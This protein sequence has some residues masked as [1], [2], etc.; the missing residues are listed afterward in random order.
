MSVLAQWAGLL[1]GAF[2][3]FCAAALIEGA[4]A[5]PA[6]GV[7]ILPTLAL[8]AS[9]AALRAVLLF[10]ASRASFRASTGVKKLL[11]QRLYDKLLAL[12]G[13]GVTGAEAVQVA[14]EGI[15]QI[16]NYFGRYLPQLFY[17]VLAPLTLFCLLAPVSLSSAAILLACAPLIPLLIAL[18]NAMARRMMRKQLSSYTSLGEFF[19]ESL[20]GMTTLKIY[21]ADGA[22]HAEMNGLAESFRRSTM[23]VLRMQLNSIIFMD[24]IA[25]GGAAL[26]VILAVRGF[27][28]GGIGMAGAVSITLLAAEFFIPLR[29]LGSYFHV[30]MNG[31]AACER[32]FQILDAPE[33]ADG[34]ESLPDGG[35]TLE[36]DGL[37]FSY[38]QGREA[39]SGLS[40]SAPAAGLTGVAGPSGCGKS[41]VA[42]LVA[43]RL[44]GREYRG[45]A[46]VGGVELRDIRLSE[47]RRRVCLVTHEDY[48]FAGTVADNLLMAKP[49]ATPQE[50]EGALRTAGLYGFFAGAGGLG[51]AVAE[52]GAN[53]SGG[54]RQ[55]LSIA[56]AALR[57]CGLY[58]FD[59]ATSSIDPESEEGILSAAAEISKSASVLMISHRLASLARADAIYAM[60]GG[61][62]A[63]RGSHSEL[64]AAGGVYGRLLREQAELESF[65]GAEA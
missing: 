3:I 46:K 44:P 25:Y 28:A 11:R 64:A 1:C 56:R 19:L 5:P 47:L 33:P 13:G 20:R 8:C 14:V 55:R 62:A 10:L 31:V 65:R 51:A 41:T 59:E 50:L 48:I 15:D 39:L 17:S 54:Q 38:G 18:I 45:S 26:G 60:E 43:G 32:V 34:E 63:E 53:L 52:G 7:R 61:R 49:D 36:M 9:A 42:R 35:L 57:G 27:L 16:E 22:R 4:Y 40:L 2:A 24:I 29:Q 21:G 37:V 12:G 23:R 30:A 6:G 58:I